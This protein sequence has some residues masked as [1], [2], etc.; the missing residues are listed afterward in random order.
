[1]K[2]LAT[3]VLLAGC[4]AVASAVGV[5]ARP[6]H[7]AEEVGRSFSL[8]TM[9]PKSFGDWREMPVQ[10][11]QV[12]NPQT[13]QL[14]DKLYSQTLARTYVNSQGYRIMLSLAYGDDQR[15]GLTAHRP[16]VCYP[17]Q[18]FTLNKQF[19]SDVVTRFGSIAARRLDTRLGPR[20]EPVTYWFNVG[21]TPI[22]SK[23]EQRM[24]ELRLGLLGQVP[25]GL[26]FRVS[27]IDDQPERA[28]AIQ[29]AF[30]VD[31]LNAVDETARLRLAGFRAPGAN[32]S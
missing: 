11:V 18:G 30:V 7:K 6:T 25:D 12:V 3:S 26:L 31:L 5:A 1:M 4:M 32:S 21:D 9:I 20:N 16:E 10:S 8:E 17:A 19:D 15:G 27:S 2:I 14:L 13:Q 29:N 23:L 28:Y 22:R 24:V